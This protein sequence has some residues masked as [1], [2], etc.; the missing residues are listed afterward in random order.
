MDKALHVLAAL[1]GA[2][3]LIFM[4]GSWVFTPEIGAQNRRF[5]INGRSGR[6]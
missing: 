6:I 4:G 1:A 3:F 5:L 2:Y